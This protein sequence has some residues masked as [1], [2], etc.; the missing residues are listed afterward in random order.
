MKPIRSVLLIAWLLFAITS[1][2]QTSQL[3]PDQSIPFL[4]AKYLDN[5][6][7]KASALENQMDKN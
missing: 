5:I 1:Y 2:A 7:D 4:P 3:V 6:S